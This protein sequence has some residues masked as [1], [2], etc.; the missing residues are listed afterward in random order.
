MNKPTLAFIG[1]G[2]MATSLIGGLL[3]QGYLAKQ[4]TASDPLEENRLRLQQQFGIHTSDNNVD[5]AQRAD[6]IL[7]AVKPQ[8]MEPVVTALSSALMHQPLVISIAAGITIASLEQWA[9]AGIPIVRCMPNT[10]ALVQT[11]A[12]GLFANSHVRSE[13]KILANDIL[14]AVG[15]TCWLEKETDIDAVTAVSG[16]GPAYYFLIMEIME[17][18]G[19]ELGLDQNIARK[20]TLQ[21]ALGAAKMAITSD[22]ELSELRQ[23][24]TSPGGTTEQAIKTLMAGDITELFR[25]AMQAAKHRAEA[26]AKELSN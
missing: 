17:K 25:Q 12:A 26:M 21:T 10:P 23:R 20:L 5:I 8:V 9:G 19:V 11:G 18:I 14:S 13:Q 2:N 3:E 24:V 22:V 6:V 4:I 16:S 1:G 7:L 15:V